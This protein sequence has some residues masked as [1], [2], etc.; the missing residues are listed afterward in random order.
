MGKDEDITEKF[1]NLKQHVHKSS[2]DSTTGL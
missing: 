2:N 1:L